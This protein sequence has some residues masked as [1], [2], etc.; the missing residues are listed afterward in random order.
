MSVTYAKVRGWPELSED[1]IKR[2]EA[3][4]KEELDP[5]WVTSEEL[6]SYQDLLFDHIISTRQTHPGEIILQ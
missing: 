2:V 3:V 1:Q 6:S 4:L 5:K